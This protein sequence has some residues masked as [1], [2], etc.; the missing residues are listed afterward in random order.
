[1]SWAF[2]GPQG[3]T[4]LSVPH[5]SPFFPSL[6]DQPIPLFL[7][8]WLT[9]SFFL[10]HDCLHTSWST[11]MYSLL[12]FWP[13]HIP[14]SSL[15]NH[16]LFFSFLCLTAVYSYPSCLTLLHISLS[17]PVHPL[18]LC[19]SLHN[20]SPF[21]S[22]PCLTILHSFPT[23]WPTALHSSLPLCTATFKSSL[24]HSLTSL[25]SYSPCLTAPMILSL[26]SPKSFLPPCLT[27]PHP[28]HPLC[29]ILHLLH[30]L[31]TLIHLLFFVRPPLHP[32]FP[33]CLISVFFCP[34]CPI[35]ST[36]PLLLNFFLHAWS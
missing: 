20:Y 23:P 17:M 27:S 33:S 2:D 18:F 6:P 13:P 29:L 34:S 25:H 8:A 7:P 35:I 16:L 11:P 3:K 24:L 26:S 21:F 9:V 31:P 22:F 19:S 1:M 5:H 32:S 36:L 12:P 15:P 28:S 4:L 14:S 30:T 10:L